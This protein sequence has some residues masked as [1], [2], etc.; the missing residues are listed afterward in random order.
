MPNVSQETQ[1]KI[2]ELQMAEQTLQSYLNQKQAFQSQKLEIESAL[3]ELEN[4]NSA[5][6]IIGNI[7]IKNSKDDLKKDL[8]EKNERM[9]LRIKSIEKQENSLKEKTQAIQQDILKNIEKSD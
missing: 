4:T 2:N 8:D 5:Y 9:S 7:M 3:K 1:E 6:K